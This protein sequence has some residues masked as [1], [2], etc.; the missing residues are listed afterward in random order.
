[1]KNTFRYFVLLAALL[2]PLTFSSIKDKFPIMVGVT[3]GVTLAYWGMVIFF[4]K[5]EQKQKSE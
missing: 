5:K 4:K 2:I 3:L 1:M